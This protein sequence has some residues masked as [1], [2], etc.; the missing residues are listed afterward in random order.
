[1]IDH[2]RAGLSCA[3]LERMAPTR[4]SR[5]Q[6]WARGQPE[7]DASLG[8]EDQLN[9]NNHDLKRDDIH[10][11]GRM[12]SRSPTC[13]P[14]ICPV[15][16]EPGTGFPVLPRRHLLVYQGATLEFRAVAAY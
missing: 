4:F 2:R 10:H 14:T 8:W 7:W 3:T 16:P 15:R 6:P 1:M 13:R 9:L 5:C 12:P 11:P